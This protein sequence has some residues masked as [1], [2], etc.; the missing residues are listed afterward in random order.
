MSFS[1]VRLKPDAIRSYK[2]RPVGFRPAEWFK[3]LVPKVRV[4]MG[5]GTLNVEPD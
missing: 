3:V 1:T 2:K 4:G 5:T